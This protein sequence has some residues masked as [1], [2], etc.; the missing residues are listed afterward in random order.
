MVFAS[1]IPLIL[2][3]VVSIDKKRVLTP[4]LVMDS[5]IS[6][7]ATVSV[8]TDSLDLIVLKDFARIIVTTEEFVILPQEY[9]LVN[10]VGKEKTVLSGQESPALIIVQTTECVTS[11]QESVLVTKAGKASTVQSN[12]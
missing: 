8:L 9:V 4:V 5:V 3:P 11:L 12:Q 6:L 7:L 10:L 1:V 2:A